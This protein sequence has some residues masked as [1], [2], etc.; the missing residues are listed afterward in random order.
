MTR[1]RLMAA[2]SDSL[3]EQWRWMRIGL[4]FLVAA[5]YIL[6]VGG[7]LEARI[8]PVITYHDVSN[9]RIVKDDNGLR[10]CFMVALTKNREAR[11]VRFMAEVYEGDDDFPT[12][13]GFEHFD[14]TPYGGPLAR[15]PAGEYTSDSCV[16]IMPSAVAA[17][18]IG[19]RLHSRYEA[20]DR[21]WNLPGP[22]LWVD[23]YRDSP[24]TH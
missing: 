19:V 15:A 23:Y 11:G 5:I 12:L 22:M 7:N 24:N 2:A 14:G 10:L 21:P 3:H 9:V 18:R 4:Y 8:W 13:R 20:P 17:Y 6:G 16:R 1:R